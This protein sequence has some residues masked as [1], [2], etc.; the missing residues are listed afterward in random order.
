MRVALAACL[1]TLVLVSASAPIGT[2]VQIDSGLV[3][4]QTNAR[5]G[6]NFWL[7][8]PYAA[9]VDGAARWTA[10]S[11]PAPWGSSPFDATQWPV[12]CFSVHHNPDVANVTAENCLNLNVYAPAGVAADAKLPIMV[13]LHGGGFAEV[14]SV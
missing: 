11:A 14:Q 8:I 9:P 1:A 12:G 2:L 7:G 13:W 3:Q 5:W 10:P 6:G 4:G